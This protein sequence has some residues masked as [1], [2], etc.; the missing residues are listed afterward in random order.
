MKTPN[1]GDNPVMLGQS[2]SFLAVVVDRPIRA[3][4]I[5]VGPLAV[6]FVGSLRP[7]IHWGGD[8]KEA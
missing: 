8:W 3:L 6:E 4:H 2:N 5:Y 1:E 7:S